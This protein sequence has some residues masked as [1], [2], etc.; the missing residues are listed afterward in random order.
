MQWF[1][2]LKTATKLLIC[3]MVVAVIAAVVGA[4][5]V[6]NIQKAVF[7]RHFSSDDF[8]KLR[9]IGPVRNIIE[10]AIEKTLL[11]EFPKIAAI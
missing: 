6:I 9:N 2:N 10:A 3:F 4:V 1:Y 7:I 5:G 11:E 8:E